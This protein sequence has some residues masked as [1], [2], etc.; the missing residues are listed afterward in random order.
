[1]KKNSYSSIVIKIGSSTL[2][3]KTGLINLRN[4]ENIVK[5]IADIKNS[6][7]DVIIVS[8]GAIGVGT[9]KLG[10]KERPADMPGKQAAA[11]VGQCELMYMYDKLF[12]VYN[13]TVAQVLLTANEFDSAEHR[14]NVLNTFERLKQYDTIPIVNENDTVAVEEIELGDNDALSALVACLTGSDALIVLS[15][16]D[17]YYTA[18]PTRDTNAE[19][20]PIIHG[21][22][23]DMLAAAGG[24]VSG[25]GTGGMITKLKA[26]CMVN[27]K[28]ITMHIINGHNPELLYDVLAGKSVGSTFLPENM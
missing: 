6:G 20:V 14:S 19:L 3:H 28:G 18:D 4:I 24:S 27:A 8:S 2:A 13:H 22:S 15:D 17:G 7:V 21:I 16:I 10:L 25:L 9:G 11:A 12:S 26:A 23:D 5:V 1:M